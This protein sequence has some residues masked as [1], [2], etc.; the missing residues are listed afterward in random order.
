MG[1]GGLRKLAIALAAVFSLCC[2]ATA[3][4]EQMV[5]LTFQPPQKLVSFDSATPGT[6]SSVTITGLPGGERLGGIDTRPGTGQLYSLGPSGRLY[7]LDPVTGVATMCPLTTFTTPGAGNGFAASPIG[8]GFD[9]LTG[10]IRVNQFSP[11]VPAED[12]RNVSID[13]DS[14]AVTVG[15]DLAYASG[16]AKFGVDPSVSSVAFSIDPTAGAKCATT[17]GVEVNGIDSL[18][19]QGSVGG[20]PDTP[21]SGKLHTVGPLGIN[22]LTPDGFDVA[23]SGVAYYATGAPPQLYTVSLTGGAATLVGTI[24][25]AAMDFLHGMAVVAP[26]P[27][28]D[29]APDP[30]GGV[31]VDTDPPE[32]T[33][34]KGPKRK[35]HKRKAKFEFGADEPASFECQLDLGD[36][37]P[38]DTAAKL[39]VKRGKHRLEVRA[40]D[41]AGNVDPTPA[42]QNWK[43]VG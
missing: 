20:S 33:I 14:G 27:P 43:L 30:G 5:A 42:S 16:D 29:A 4:A 11:G 8:F 39:K 2:S 34:L 15:G 12:D 38:C 7:T 31:A 37:E 21:E 9:P 19:T 17:Y 22:A 13:P 35:T 36:F 10:G 23:P 28:C 1:S 24:T 32:T 40:I 18:V 6:V 3:S 26:A 41:S 25:V